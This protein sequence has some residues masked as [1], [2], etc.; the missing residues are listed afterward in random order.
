MAQELRDLSDQG[1]FLCTLR[2]CTLWFW[3]P[4]PWNMA[5]NKGIWD[6]KLRGTNLK[7]TNLKSLI[8]VRTKIFH[9]IQEKCNPG[10]EPKCCIGPC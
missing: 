7:G 6:P 10:H 1:V 3:V 5:L 4:K 2:V 9:G 8:R